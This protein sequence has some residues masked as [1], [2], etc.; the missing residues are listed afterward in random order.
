LSAALSAQT[1]PDWRLLVFDNNSRADER[2]ERAAFP[3]NT[4]IIYS[5]VNLGFAEANNRAA[6]ESS[7]PYIVFLNPDAFPE[8]AWL[9]ALLAEIESAPNTAA[10]GSTQIRADAEHL[11]DGTGDVLHA[12]GL[13]YRSSYGRPRGPAPPRGETFAACAAAMIIRRDAYEAAGG[14]D[15]DYFCYFEDV[16]LC[17]RMRLAGWRIVQS[18]DAVVAHV[19]GG[20]SGA[21]SPFADFH[22]ARNRTWTFIKCMPPLLFWPL[23][24]AHLAASTLAVTAALLCGHGLAGWRGFVSGLIS[25]RAA[26]RKRRDLQA[27]RT[28]S[29]AAIAH[30]LAWSPLALFSKRPIVRKL[31][32]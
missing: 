5:P 13:A 17:F 18:P 28:A 16:D 12:S 31:R 4:S 8:P 7:A 14:F 30:A 29:T 10:I 32:P 6:R 21:R 23:L 27:S 19:G 2:P 15:P 20:A 25:W 22:G 24:P 1:E 26:W 9:A 3:P 11:F